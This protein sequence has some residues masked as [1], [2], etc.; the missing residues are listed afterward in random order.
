MRAVTWIVCLLVAA[1]GAIEPDGGVTDGA[2]R[3][4][5]SLQHHFALVP[6][7]SNLPYRTIDYQ[8]KH[9]VHGMSGDYTECFLIKGSQWSPAQ[10]HRLNLPR[11]IGLPKT[12]DVTLAAGLFHASGA[13]NVS[14]PL[15]YCDDSQF[16]YRKVMVNST[17]AVQGKWYSSSADLYMSFL[18]DPDTQT[19][20][21]MTDHRPG[22][23]RVQLGVPVGPW[24][25]AKAAGS[26]GNCNDASLDARLLA[27]SRDQLNVA[28]LVGAPAAT[29]EQ[30]AGATLAGIQLLA[31]TC[32][33]RPGLS[34]PVFS[35]R[36]AVQYEVK[37]EGHRLPG[38]WHVSGFS[39]ESI[40][41]Y[42]TAFQKAVFQSTRWMAG[43]TVRLP[44]W[45]I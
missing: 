23:P 5:F 35:V 26:V 24:I 34:A 44:P 22:D 2:R 19:L 33:N 17:L 3:A 30:P 28:N 16:W 14:P 12:V 18:I 13:W 15:I 27:G 21:T 42:W 43:V 1:C 37:C 32:G 45:C 11:E 8:V 20:H 36:L 31:K 29:E 40:D 4:D 6:H 9:V 7:I 41:G 39:G 38:Y 25:A 10:T